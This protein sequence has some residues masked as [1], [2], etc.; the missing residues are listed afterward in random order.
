[1][2]QHDQSD[3]VR[4]ALLFVLDRSAFSIRTLDDQDDDRDYWQGKSPTEK[5][6]ALEYLR[7]MAYG[8]A[9]TARLQRV[10]AVVELGSD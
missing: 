1:V 4:P 6:A 10:L 5:L 8:A 3:K 2:P 9:A 7:R